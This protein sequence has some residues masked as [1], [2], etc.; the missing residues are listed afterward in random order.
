MTIDELEKTLMSGT[1]SE[2]RHIRCANCGQPLKVVFSEID[3]RKALN[4]SCQLRCYR[5]NLDGFATTP[6]WVTEHGATL[7]TE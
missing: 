5:A 7:R 3:G 1:L 2:V 6:P 4:I